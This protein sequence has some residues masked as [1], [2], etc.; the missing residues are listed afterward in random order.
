M[1]SAALRDRWV[2]PQVAK[3]VAGVEALAKGAVRL[4]QAAYTGFAHCLQAE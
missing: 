3:W 4:L 2:E 1:G